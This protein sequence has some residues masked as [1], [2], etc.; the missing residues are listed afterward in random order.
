MVPLS[1]ASR[2][3]PKIKRPSTVKIE[4]VLDSTYLQRVR[5]LGSCFLNAVIN[6]SRPLM[7][8]L[9]VSSQPSAMENWEYMVM[10]KGENIRN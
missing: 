1:G 10:M 8:Q 4:G 5:F 9:A 2:L 3:K 6:A 7:K